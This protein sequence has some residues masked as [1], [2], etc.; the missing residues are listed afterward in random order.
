MDGA[1]GQFQFHMPLEHVRREKH[2]HADALTKKTQYLIMKEMREAHVRET[3]EVMKGFNFLPQEQFDAL[4]IMPNLDS[5]GK[6]KE[7]EEPELEEILQFATTGD[8][9]DEPEYEELEFL[10]GES[11]HL[12]KLS[13]E[14]TSEAD[15][16][17]CP[18]SACY[19]NRYN[20][21]R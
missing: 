14:H 18:G 15:D 11:I 16:D 10:E 2:Q 5:K 17:D 3:G 21:L 6:E 7:P 1:A 20:A 19:G 12:M 4:E 9:I 8:F 13:E